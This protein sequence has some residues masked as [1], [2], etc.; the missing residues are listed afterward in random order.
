MEKVI[1]EVSTQMIFTQ[2]FLSIDIYK[3]IMIAFAIFINAT[4]YFQYTP[5]WNKG[6]ELYGLTY[7]DLFGPFFLFALTITFEKSFSRRLEIYGK[8]KTYRHFIR[9][10]SIYILIGFIITLNI[11]STGI[12][13]KWGT[14][15]MLGMTGL[16]L[17]LIIKVR[18]Y[19][20][21]LIALILLVVYQF[22]ILQINELEIATIPHGGVIGLLS[23]FSFAN[24]A[25]IVNELFIKNKNMTQFGSLGIIFLI[26]GAL[27]SIFLN[28]SRQLVNMSFIFISLG[29]SILVC[30]VL[31]YMFEE[32]SAK[33]LWLKKERFLS[34]LGKNTLFLYILQSFF[35][36]IPYFLL[37]Y[38]TIPIVFFSF[39]VLMV[40]LNYVL[41]YLLDNFQIYLVF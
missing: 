23:W 30:L 34:V 18:A 3:G 6:S 39:G 5:T 14:L 27:T 10:F 28:I 21:V 16:F 41:A 33:W 38:N 25:S 19:L 29:I 26:L 17:L 24:F 11:E 22:I 15:Q 32:L 20:R 1:T 37:P 31:F 4:S 9:R 12:M 40:F 7:V 35:K 36:I 13:L 2:R 8:F